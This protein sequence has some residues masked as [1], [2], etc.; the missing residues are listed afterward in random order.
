MITRVARAL[1]RLRFVQLLSSLFKVRLV[2][3]LKRKLGDL[4]L[5]FNALITQ[6]DV[7]PFKFDV[8]ANFT[9]VI[10]RIAEGLF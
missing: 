5:Y 10:P 9:V 2:L 8:L 1:F 6:L 3:A 4:G 7:R